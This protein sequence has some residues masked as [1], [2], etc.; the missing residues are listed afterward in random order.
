MPESK[1]KVAK[2]YDYVVDG[3]FEN[4]LFNDKLRFKGS[5]NQ[6]V[7]HIENGEFVISKYN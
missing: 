4:C 5:S 3:P 7:W 2:M 6:T 1:L